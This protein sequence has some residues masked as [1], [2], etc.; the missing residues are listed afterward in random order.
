MTPPLL[1]DVFAPP[2]TYGATAGIYT[3]E[4]LQTLDEARTARLPITRDCTCGPLKY[5]A[6]R[7]R[8]DH[9][10]TGSQDI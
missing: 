2:V 5:D 4:R 7:R 6:C 1:R 10:F 8:G 9:D 3:A